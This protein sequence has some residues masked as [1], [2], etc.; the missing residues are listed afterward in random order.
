[1]TSLF[2][3]RPGLPAQYTSIRYSQ[4]PEDIGGVSSV[5]SNGDP[6]DNA[7]AEAENSLYKKVLINREGPWQDAG[8]LTVA[9]AEWVSWYNNERF[10]RR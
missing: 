5:G 1:M 8:R 4:R 9:S 6:D 7:A 10:V 2:T 3:F